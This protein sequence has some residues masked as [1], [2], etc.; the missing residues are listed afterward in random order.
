L[1]PQSFATRLVAW[2]RAHGRHALPWQNTRDPYRVW[3]SE[4]MLQQTQVS[5]VL[6]YYERFLAKF[7]SV[8]ELAAAPS[9]QVMAL[10]SGL[11]YYSRAR[12]LHACAQAVARDHG[13]V[14]PSTSAALAELPGIGPSTAA[15]IASFC[16]GERIAIFDGNVKRV[17]ARWAGFEADLASSKNAKALQAQVQT[18]VPAT[19]ADMPAFTQG[20][21]DL[22]ATLCTARKPSCLLCP[23][24][25][26]CVAR[27]DGRTEALP[28]AIK[29]LKRSAQSWWLLWQRNAAGE[30]LL[31]Q[32]P[33]GGI[34]RG[35][36]APPVFASEA[37]AMQFAGKRRVDSSSAELHKLTH[38][39]LHLHHWVLPA[40]LGSQLGAFSTEAALALGLPAPV[41][42]FLIDA[43]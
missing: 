22:G 33:D 8:V 29:K 40:P 1:K 10:W 26:D 27:R 35:L 3:L 16:F 9:D 13:G 23:V 5:T 41:R 25:A 34:W 32:R 11:G 6:G 14:F 20:L 19:G 30:W 28:H 2:Q 4:I 42:R 21:M 39:D 17:A 36:F 38:L 12:N 31:E 24:S 15:A 43:S 37:E 7:P 18:W